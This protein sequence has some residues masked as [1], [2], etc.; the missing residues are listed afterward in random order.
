MD[1]FKRRNSKA[2]ESYDSG[3]RDEIMKSG[4]LYMFTRPVYAAGKMPPLIVSD[5]SS[6]MNMLC[7]QEV[8]NL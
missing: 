7:I 5:L 8:M 3:K 6:D 4:F 2:H 1:N